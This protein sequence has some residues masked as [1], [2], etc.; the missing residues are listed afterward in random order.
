MTTP[1]ERI[2]IVTGAGDLVGTA[3]ARA[4]AGLGYTVAAVDR[5]VALCDGTLDA[6]SALDRPGRAFEAD[7]TLAHEAEATV[8]RIYDEMGPPTALVNNPQFAWSAPRMQSSED[9][10]DTVL[11]INLR[12][13]FLMSRAVQY[14]LVQQG[15]GRIVNVASALPLDAGMWAP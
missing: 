12:A 7:L 15:S 14:H 2:A 3:A 11:S 4:A 1:H 5:R 13:A 8:G 10:W 9:D 6:L